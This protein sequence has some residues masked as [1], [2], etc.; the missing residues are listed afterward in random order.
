MFDKVT[1]PEDG[2]KIEIKGDKLV[3]PDN[4]ILG[5]MWGDAIG[6]DI[7]RASLRIW[8]AAVQKTYGGN[9]KVAWM[10]LYAGE[11]AMAMYN[12]PLPPDTLKA[13]QEFIVSISAR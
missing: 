4:P 11:E 10:R 7:T 9:R 6:P 13:C 3:V 2:K 8:D 1:V 12:D 5:I